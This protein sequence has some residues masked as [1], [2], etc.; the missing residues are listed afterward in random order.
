MPTTESTVIVD[1]YRHAA[2]TVA[3]SNSYQGLRIHALPGLHE[4]LADLLVRHIRKGARVLDL[5][6]GSGAM[7]ARLKDLGYSVHAIDY[8]KENF[9]AEDVPFTQANLNDDFSALF[10]NETF[11]AVLAS[12]IIEHL[13]NPRHF[14]R[15]CNK[16]LDAG[17]KVILSTPNLHNGGSMASF[18]RTGQ[19]LWFSDSDYSIHGHI[20]PITQWEVAH[21]VREA[22]LVKIWCGSFGRGATRIE[23]SPRLK[24][25]A[26]ILALLTSVPGNLR[27]EIYVCIAQKMPGELPSAAQSR[28]EVHEPLKESVNE[29]IRRSSS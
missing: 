1:Q 13:E 11:Q 20:A 24:L 29:P 23:G 26:K 9:S 5:A 4:Y 25:V 18:V 10:P 16:I 17:G 19:F 21:C 27:G 12:E 8:V 14:L 3:G 2:T 15:Q 22:E 28:P 6:A 7:S